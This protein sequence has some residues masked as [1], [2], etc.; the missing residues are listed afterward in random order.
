MWELKVAGGHCAGEAPG[1]SPVDE[2]C[3]SPCLLWPPSMC[4]TREWSFCPGCKH[5]NANGCSP[6]LSVLSCDPEWTEQRQ[7]SPATPWVP[8][9]H[10]IDEWNMFPCAHCFYLV[11]FAVV[12]FSPILT[13]NICEVSQAIGKWNQG[14]PWWLNSKQSACQ[15]KRYWFDPWVGKISGEGNDNP[16]QY[17]CLGNPIDRGAWWT[18]GCKSQIWLSNQTIDNQNTD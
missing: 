5:S 18:W 11:I 17:S 13:F 4:Q 14:L 6:G 7:A 1:G 10:R 2:S 3:L 15:C 16:L 9:T 8:G 12:G